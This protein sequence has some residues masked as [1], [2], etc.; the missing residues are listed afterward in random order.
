MTD[1][2]NAGAPTLTA[3]IVAL[4]AGLSDAPTGLGLLLLPQFVF[5]A[6]RLP[7]PHDFTFVRFVGAFVFGVGL[8]YFL[9]FLRRDPAVR[10]ARLVAVLE[11]T[12]VVRTSIA[13]YVT[14][15]IARG[16]LA[17]AWGFVAAFDAVLAALQFALLARRR[18]VRG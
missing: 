16:A 7:A 10:G 3:T 5:S 11:A 6:L 12:A 13:L 9:P 15:A 14:V 4:F 18:V 8:A 2:R 1:G 17:P